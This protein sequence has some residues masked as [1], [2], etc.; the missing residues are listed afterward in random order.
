MSRNKVHEWAWDSSNSKWTDQDLPE[1]IIDNTDGHCQPSVVAWVGP[2]DNG[3][4]DAVSI[5]LYQL[6]GDRSFAGGITYIVESSFDTR[7]GWTADTAI[8]TPEYANS[9]P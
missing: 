2:D 9:P 7:S 6:W 3:T 4:Q 8:L 5:R 1:S